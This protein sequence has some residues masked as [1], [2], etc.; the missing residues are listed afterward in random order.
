MYC[1]FL[2]ILYIILSYI[3]NIRGKYKNKNPALTFLMQYVRHKKIPHQESQG[4]AQKGSMQNSFLCPFCASFG[5]SQLWFPAALCGVGSSVP[6][7]FF[8][9]EQTHDKPCDSHF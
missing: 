5:V 1:V 7:Y 3:P 8:T 6:A 4:M 2:Y 9:V